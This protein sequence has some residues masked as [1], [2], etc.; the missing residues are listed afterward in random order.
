MAIE[1]VKN[2]EL[3]GVKENCIKWDCSCGE[4]RFAS[5]IRIKNKNYTPCPECGCIRSFSKAILDQ[6]ENELN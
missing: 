6:F 5:L 4:V 1:L 2:F 3:D